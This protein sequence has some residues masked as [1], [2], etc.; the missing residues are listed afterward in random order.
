MKPDVE[1]LNLNEID[2]MFDELLLTSKEGASIKRATMK[3]S[4]KPIV[5]DA[6]NNL[7]SSGHNKTG[8]LL[9]SLGVIAKVRDNTAYAATGARKGPGKGNHFHLIN[10]G[11][12]VR[13]TATG[14][15]R[16]S[17]KGSK[18][19]DSAVTSNMSNIPKELQEAFDRRMKIF[20]D[21]KY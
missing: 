4:L 10:S 20:M 18:F 5:K 9:K 14:A 21:K 17:V 19:F 8:N 11:T 13:T 6:K 12:K 7:R 3:D 2:K 16:G 1:I 15:N